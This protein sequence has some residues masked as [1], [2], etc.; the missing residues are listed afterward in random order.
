MKIPSQTRAKIKRELLQ[1]IKRSNNKKKQQK[2]RIQYIIIIYIK[3]TQK[4]SPKTK[5][6]SIEKMNKDGHR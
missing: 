5:K 1:Q 4:K 6:T 3:N 2:K